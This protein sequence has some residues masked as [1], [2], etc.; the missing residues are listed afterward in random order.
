MH[1]I[2]IVLIGLASNLD[3]LGIGVS[4][5]MRSTRIPFVSNLIIAL[6][7]MLATYSTLSLGQWVSSYVPPSVANLMGGLLIVAIGAWTIGSG[8]FN[9][10]PAD[11]DDALTAVLRNPEHADIDQD[12]VISWQESISLG[13][14]LALNC[15]ASGFGAGIS[16]VSPFWTTLSV[17]AFSLLTVELGVRA[18]HRIARAWLGRYSNLIAGLLLIGIGVYEILI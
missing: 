2:T 3:N 5:G 7:S 8:F 1:W 6:I 16:G 10:S 9:R 12:R 11:T 14:A 13:V 15:M 4:F 18:G 17:G